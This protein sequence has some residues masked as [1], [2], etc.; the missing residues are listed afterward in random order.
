[1]VEKKGDEKRLQQRLHLYPSGTTDERAPAEP[2]LTRGLLTDLK[3]KANERA[4]VEQQKPTGPLSSYEKLKRYKPEILPI[5][6][7]KRTAETDKKWDAFI[8]KYR[9]RYR[10][11]AP[12]R[13]Y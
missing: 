2:M 13:H 11:V 12:R 7:F 4:T 1:M 3:K 8:G 9:R 6:E 10:V 5:P